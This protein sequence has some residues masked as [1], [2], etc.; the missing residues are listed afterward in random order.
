MEI[1]PAIDLRGG[2]CVRLLQGDY[3][4][5]TVFGDDPAAVARHWC[6]LGAT[7]LHV[8]D[9]DG[10]KAGEPRQLDTVGAIVRAASVPVELGGGIRTQAAAQQ[11]LDVGVAQVILGTAA[12]DRTVAADMA[13]AL[14]DKLVGG[15][16]ARG[17]LVAVRGWLEGT[18][19][20]AVELAQELCRLGLRRIIYT[21][22]G[23]DGML[24]G[25]N[26][27]AMREMVYAVPEASVIASGGVSSI[28]DVRALRDAGAAGAIIG[29]A[30]YTGD[31]DLGKAIA[32]AC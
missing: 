5:E 20:H 28:A 31:I 16:D 14:G 8:V 6:S 4:R 18:E 30:L 2:H 7:R 10:A 29:M 22:I 25:A 15:I 23:R 27:A 12:L 19:V 1:I 9:L 17:G 24:Q 11:A 13:A 3:D 32:A 26:I 21:D